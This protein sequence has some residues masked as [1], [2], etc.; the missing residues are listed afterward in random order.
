MMLDWIGNIGFA[1]PSPQLRSS[2]SFCLSTVRRQCLERLGDGCIGRFR[3]G[4]VDHLV[5]DPTHPAILAGGGSHSH[6]RLLVQQSHA[7]P[8]RWQV[9][10]QTN[11]DEVTASEI[12]SQ[13]LMSALA[14]TIDC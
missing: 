8:R 9:Q 7:S 6:F 1:M 2:S 11:G 13:F 12:K 10:V 4:V 3:H 5:P 14:A